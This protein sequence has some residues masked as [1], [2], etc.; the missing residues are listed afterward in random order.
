VR[1]NKGALELYVTVEENEA[2]ALSAQCALPPSNARNHVEQRSSRLGGLYWV[3]V[4]E[5]EEAW[6]RALAV[7]RHLFGS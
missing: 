7:R 5:S 6:Y 3:V 2:F 4:L 1:D